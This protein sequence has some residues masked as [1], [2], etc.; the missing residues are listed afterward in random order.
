MEKTVNKNE[1]KRLRNNYCY[2][3]I[4]KAITIQGAKEKSPS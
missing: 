2:C 1:A 4:R 3:K